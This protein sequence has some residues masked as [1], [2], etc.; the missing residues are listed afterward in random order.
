MAAVLA[1]EGV[2]MR[3]VVIGHSGDT[4]DLDYLCSLLATGAW[5][6]MDRFGVEDRLP[7]AL[8]VEVVASLCKAGF[9][10]QLVISTDASYWSGRLTAEYKLRTRPNWSPTR[11]FE[12][13]IPHLLEAGVREEDVELMLVRN[14]RSIFTPDQPY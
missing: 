4:T 1:G 2:D 9:A 10:G 5:L 14:P 12:Y 13:V 11:I 3:R 8:R 7:D 6:G